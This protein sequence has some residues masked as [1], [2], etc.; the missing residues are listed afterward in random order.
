MGNAE[1]RTR[2]EDI[3]HDVAIAK[4]PSELGEFLKH[5]KVI[6]DEGGTPRV[7][8]DYAAWLHVREYMLGLDLYVEKY[9]KMRFAHAN[10]LKSNRTVPP[11]D[12]SNTQEEEDDLDIN[13]KKKKRGGV[14]KK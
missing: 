8:M 5:V 1:R 9:F 14:N 2:T 13:P 4:L 6:E 11:R 12:T 3:P 7:S 10:K